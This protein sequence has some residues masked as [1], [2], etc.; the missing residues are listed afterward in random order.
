M[1]VMNYKNSKKYE[2]AVDIALNYYL[3]NYNNG[4]IHTSLTQEISD[5][6]IY[7]GE[8]GMEYNYY[9]KD[10]QELSDMHRELTLL[11]GAIHSYYN[12]E[13]ISSLGT[14]NI[15]N[16]FV[17]FSVFFEHLYEN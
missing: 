11:Y 16:M 4:F 12:Y 14:N 6:K 10:F 13:K 1:N 17:D 2:V 5:E 7:F 15:F 8:I 3:S 9:H